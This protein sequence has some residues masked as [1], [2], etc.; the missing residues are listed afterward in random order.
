MTAEV[1]NTDAE[2]RL[3]LAD[4]LIEA[5]KQNPQFIIDCATLTGAAKVA[6]GNDYHSVL[7]MDNQLVSEL[8]KAAEQCREPFWRLP[9]S[10]EFHRSPDFIFFCRYWQCRISTS[11]A[12]ASTA[13]AFLSYF[14][15]NYAQNWLHIDCSATYRKSACDLWELVQQD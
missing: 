4:G 10:E 9:F 3:V 7:S 11:G 5:D 2:G 15:E 12:G 8:F 13:T 14:V 6:V 1:L